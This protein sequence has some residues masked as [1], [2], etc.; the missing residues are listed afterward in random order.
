MTDG[1]DCLALTNSNLLLSASASLPCKRL[2]NGCLTEPT[3]WRQR[4]LGLCFCNNFRDISYIKA[5]S[6]SSP[7]K[8]AF[9][10]QKYILISSPAHQYTLVLSDGQG[11]VQ[12]GELVMMMRCKV[13]SLPANRRPKSTMYGLSR[14]PNEWGESDSIVNY[15]LLSENVGSD[16]SNQNLGS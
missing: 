7:G 5:F 11:Q 9:F 2:G 6:K 3:I 4:S 15:I 12:G 16:S 8:R 1:Y 14:I 10:Y 13:H